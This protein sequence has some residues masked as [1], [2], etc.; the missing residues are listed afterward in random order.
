MRGSSFLQGPDDGVSVDGAP[1]ICLFDGGTHTLD[2]AGA[3]LSRC[4]LSTWSFDASDVQTQLAHRPGTLCMVIDLPGTRGL[5][6]LQLLRKRAVSL[7]AI[8]IVDEHEAI[9]A[10]RLTDA[11]VLDVLTRPASAR[12]LLTWI[13]CVMLAQKSSHASRLPEQP[14]AVAEVLSAAAL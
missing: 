5:S 9:P 7:P 14:Q 1:S 6:L 11:C 4:G 3:V 8:L 2:A 12:E 13:E 10:D